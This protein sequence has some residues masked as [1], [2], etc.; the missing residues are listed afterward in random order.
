MTV[1]TA[2]QLLATE[3]PPMR[4]AVDGVLAEGVN[5]LAGAPKFGK[6]WM[7]LGLAVAIADGGFAFGRIPVEEGDVLYLA[8]EDNGRRL[9][10]RLRLLLG[11]APG[12]R[13]LVLATRWDGIEAVE[14]WLKNHPEARL[15]VVD[16]LQRVRPPQLRGEATYGADYRALQPFADLAGQHNVCVLVVHHTRKATGEDFVD[17]VSGTF[18]LS[19]AADAILV[20]RRSR[21]SGAAIVKVTGR[22]VEERELALDFS[23]ATGAWV[24]LDSP[25]MHHDVGDTRRQILDT[26]HG[27]EPM[28]PKAI[29]EKTGIDHDLVKQTVRRMATDG[30]L[31]TAAGQYRHP[32]TPVPLSLLSPESPDPASPG[33]T[34]DRSDSATEEA[35]RRAGADHSD[36]AV[37]PIVDS[38]PRGF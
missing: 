33:D 7:A 22:D 27:S 32:D 35:V 2:D 38:I 17:E 37:R 8:L 10:S 34:G 5:V 1:W 24:L 9:K 26:L 25:A 21:Q 15:V 18:G 3:F 13:R 31:L 11:D 23:P 28:G 36:A 14:T 19:G 12:P 30:Q 20:A 29:A 6:S 4:W 16:V